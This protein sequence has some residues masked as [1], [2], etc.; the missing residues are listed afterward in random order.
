[1]KKGLKITL[2]VLGVLVGII[3][4]D[5]LQ[6]KIFDNS[7]FIKI[8]KDYNDGDVKYIDKGL[9]VNHYYCNNNE[10]VTTWKGTK[11]DCSIEENKN[12]I[13]NYSKVIENKVIEL[14][15]PKDWKYEELSLE[16]NYKFGLK[17]YKENEENYF[18]LYYYDKGFEVCG[19]GRE[20]RNLTLNNGK[21]ANI[22]YYDGS[23]MWGDISFSD[24]DENIAFINYETSDNE[25][26]EIIKTFN[27][28]NVNEITE[29]K[30]DIGEESLTEITSNN[31]V[32][33]TIKNKTL[34]STG[35]TLLLKNN[36]NK[37]Y[38]YG[39]PYE[40]EIK[41]NDKWYK[42]NVDLSFTLP[43]FNLKPGETKEI[44][45]NWEN[46]Y[47]GLSSGT[48][49]IIKNVDYRNNNGESKS[50]NV[51]VEFTIQ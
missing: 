24:I 23:N 10:K 14:N 39:N 8:R 1:M 35:A 45:L 36:S 34:T 9:F 4:L 32:V 48:Y 3:I 17:I 37:I 13:I 11:F 19:T 46:G 29:N 43:A 30:F 16:N 40:M 50:Y 47:G 27:L 18:V 25:A 26:F 2:I 33:L 44:D 38:Q 41:L 42:I 31:D 12:Q 7:P 28:K 21:I 6:A 22:G 51:A 49:R 20:T 5:T 15:I